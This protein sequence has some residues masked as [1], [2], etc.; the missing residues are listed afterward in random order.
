MLRL[1]RE[2]RLSLLRPA[3]FQ[4]AR[5]QDPASCPRGPRALHH[6]LLLLPQLILWLR[7]NRELH[8]QLQPQLQHRQEHLQPIRGPLRQPEHPLVR[9]PQ[10]SSGL[11][12]PV[13]A[14]NDPAPQRP[15]NVPRIVPAV[16]QVLGRGPAHR[17]A[18]AP[19][20]RPDKFARVAHRVPVDSRSDPA[21][22]VRAAP[23]LERSA[24]APAFRKQ[25]RASR[26]MRANRPLRAAAR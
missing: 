17:K 23:R 8:L 4:L 14:R 6:L 26:S 11:R 25:N 13:P 10:F 7:Q 24:P 20:P 5:R 9:P 3:R 12:R 22:D 18:C 2:S 1:L 19:P 15:A 21:V 16:L